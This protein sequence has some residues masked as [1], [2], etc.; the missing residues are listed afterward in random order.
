[1]FFFRSSRDVVAL[2]AIEE[3]AEFRSE[4]SEVFGKGWNGG[5]VG[6][7]DG[8]QGCYDAVASRAGGESKTP[9][10]DIGVGRCETG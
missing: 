8:L 9:V 4:V 2:L 3:V 10:L 6:L 5:S 1:M 7:G